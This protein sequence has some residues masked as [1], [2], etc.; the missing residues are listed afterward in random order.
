MD[1]ADSDGVSWRCT[2]E[3]RAAGRAMAAFSTAEEALVFATRHLL[4]LGAVSWTEDTDDAHGTRIL[5]APHGTYRIER[6]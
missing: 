5:S 6:C 4:L 3:A 2:F 1:A